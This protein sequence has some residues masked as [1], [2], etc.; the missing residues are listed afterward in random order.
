MSTWKQVLK[1]LDDDVMHVVG[2]VYEATLGLLK[3]FYTLEIFGRDG[4]IATGFE[5]LKPDARISPYYGLVSALMK[6]IGP[7]I[8]ELIAKSRALDGSYSGAP[9]Q[10]IEAISYV[11]LW[12]AHRGSVVRI[13]GTSRDEQPGALIASWMDGIILPLLENSLEADIL[14]A[15]V[16]SCLLLCGDDELESMLSVRREYFT[17]CMRRISSLGP[18][19]YVQRAVSLFI[20]CMKYVGPN[21]VWGNIASSLALIK[22]VSGE[23]DR[24][25]LAVELAAV[26]CNMLPNHGQCSIVSSGFSSI[27]YLMEKPISPPLLEYRDAFIMKFMDIIELE[28]YRVHSKTP[29]IRLKWRSFAHAVLQQCTVSLTWST[30]STGMSVL[31]ALNSFCS[32]FSGSQTIGHSINCTALLED[33]LLWKLPTIK[34]TSVKLCTMCLL[35]SYGLART[36]GID[37]DMLTQTIADEVEYLPELVDDAE[38]M[39]TLERVQYILPCVQKLEELNVEG[40]R[41]LIER[42]HELASF[43]TPGTNTTI[44]PL[45]PLRCGIF[46]AKDLPDV[47]YASQKYS[48][49]FT[50][51]GC[52]DPLN[53]QLQFKVIGRQLLLKFSLLNMTSIPFSDVGLEVGLTGPVQPITAVHGGNVSHIFLGDMRPCVAAKWYALFEIQNF[54]DVSFFVRLDV[55]ERGLDCLP[56]VVPAENFLVKPSIRLHEFR[57]RLWETLQFSYARILCEKPRRSEVF[58]SKFFKLA[59]EKP[60]TGKFLTELW[61]SQTVHGKWLAIVF[62]TFGGKSRA[63]IRSDDEE[64][65][66]AAKKDGFFKRVLIRTDTTWSPQSWDWC[67]G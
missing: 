22:D 43:S 45:G 13:E 17:L 34:F 52:S 53:V 16:Q 11:L 62:S 26:A 8:H 1:L 9:S 66:A 56:C 4:E 50:V 5:S 30:E 39:S 3:E 65:L 51:T 54:A 2:S 64:V 44:P 24:R 36:N 14:L 59:L 35:S 29:A 42:L 61:V 37:V 6:V 60:Q 27:R 31:R 49:F 23:A 19:C 15:C 32:T 21:I 47:N 33:I 46:A 67:R 10:S 20:R 7:K 12:L 40:A 25:A 48:S 18:C 58:I 38:S 28:M 41:K 57:E 55:N 63:E